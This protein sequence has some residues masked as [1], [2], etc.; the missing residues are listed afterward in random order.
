MRMLHTMRWVA[1]AA[2]VCLVAVGSPA[3]SAQ[4]CQPLACS[5]ILVDLPYRLDFDSDRGKIQA[6][7]GLG[8]GFTYVDPPTNG[9]G[10]LP[11]N[12]LLETSPPGVLDVTTTA[13]QAFQNNDS[14]DNALG[15]GIDAPSQVTRLETTL[16]D[17]PVGSAFQQGGL[18]FGND[19]DNYVKLIILSTPSGEHQ[20]VYEME[21]GGALVG[22]EADHA[23]L[24]LSG[25]QLTLSLI[26]DP[27]NQRIEA[28]YRVDSGPVTSL[29]WFDAPPEFFS[30]DAARIDPEI[31]TDSFGGIFAT[32]ANGPA[33]QVFQF[34]NFSVGVERDVLQT[35]LA[36]GIA[37]TRKSYPLT[38]PTSMAFG[39]DGRLYVTELFGTIHALT[40]NDDREVIAD[41]VITTLG[42]RL[43]LGITVD[44]L[45]T[46]DNVMLWVSHSHPVIFGGEPNTSMVT[47][48][49]GPGFADREDV[50]T[51]LPRSFANHATNSIHF[52]PDGKLYLAQGGNTNAGA[53]SSGGSD[54][55]G[56][57]QEQPLSAALLVADVRAPGFDGSCNN[58]SDIFGPPPCDVTPYATGLRNAYDFVFHSNGSLYAPDNAS[59]VNATFPPSPTQPCFGMGD[60]DPWNADPPGNDPGPQHDRLLLIQPGKYYGHPNPSRNECVFGDGGYQG[61]SP[62]SNHESPIYDLGDHRSPNGTLEYASSEPH[63]GALKGNLVLANL[64]V[65]DDLTRVELSEDG[66]S[67]VRSQSLAQD[68]DEP[69]PLAQ[70]GDGTIYVGEFAAD[71]VTALLPVNLGCWTERE[72][73]PAELLDAGGAAVGG[74][75]YVVAGE[76]ASAHSSAVY[77]YNPATDAWRA[78]PN[79]PGPAVENPAV[80]ALG[81][82]LY[83]FGGST[84]SFS[85]A[86]SNAAVFDPGQN[87]WSPLPD[88]PTARGGATAQA[89]GGKIYVVGGLAPDG[90]SLDTVDVFEPDAP[91]GGAWSSAAAMSTRRDNSGSAVLGGKLYVFGGGTRNPG[92]Y[93]NHTLSSVEI[94]DPAT[95]TWAPGAPMPTGRRTMA[96]G[97]LNGRAQLIGGELSTSASGTFFANEEYDPITGSWRTLTPMRTPRHGSAAGTIGETIYVAGGGPEAGS[98]FSSLNEAFSFNRSQTGTPGTGVGATAPTVPP[99]CSG[100]KATIVGSSGRDHLRG[101]KRGDVIV[102][103]GGLDIVSGLSGRDLICGGKGDDV[104]RG[105]RGQDA[106]EGGKG[107]DDLIG[108]RG[109]DSCTGGG[110]SDQGTGCEGGLL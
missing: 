13:G 64:S 79:L 101:T 66:R 19:E 5:E 84:S 94:Y 57:M 9:S 55:F 96:V 72:P 51:G 43:T 50:I 70:D 21:V 27:T 23:S 52:G 7:N 88:L 40:L 2:T 73:L 89:L 71:Q 17:P 24:D 98:S 48:L 45:S 34:D 30:F 18:W 12:L 15:V 109:R 86:V 74:E 11:G 108:G 28:L 107:S 75:L 78:G 85:G 44:P 93:A 81:G 10:Y 103:L 60:P 67:V 102:G 95:D 68:F 37:F 46:P 14:Q 90:A 87:A 25:R 56:D 38:T 92:G 62:L 26:A 36:D 29:G 76:E 3:A 42:T 47:R 49:S 59:G 41:Q 32:H 58:A 61:V 16:R 22:H 65:G 99:R 54:E 91:G 53:P 100:R 110:G 83:V 69:L 106:I 77:A 82:K 39:P 80:V 104:L 4:G 20:V 63:C 1:L 105:N 97:T 8:T 35:P 33:P 31:G 6:G